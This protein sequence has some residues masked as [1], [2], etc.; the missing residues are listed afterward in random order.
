MS[1][2]IQARVLMDLLTPA[3]LQAGCVVEGEA[4][5]IKRLSDN[6]VVDTNKAAVAAA[7][8][9]GA[10]VVTLEPEAPAA[11]A[12]PATPVDPAAPAPAPGGDATAAVT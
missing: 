6:G 11:P 9:A 5:A 10:D 4:A 1:K 12:A 7:L 3:L 2:L 8:K